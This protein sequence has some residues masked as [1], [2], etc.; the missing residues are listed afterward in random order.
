MSAT[1]QVAETFVSIQG[2]ST[3]AGLPCFFIRLSGCNLRCLYCDTRR[4]YD[5]GRETAV[6]QLVAAFPA[7]R[8]AIAEITGGEPLL[9]QGF[10][11]LALGL[12][13]QGGRP[14]LVETNGSC[15]LSVIPDGVIAIMDLKCPGS[16]EAGSMDF[17]N[18]A[19]LRPYDEVKFVVGDRRDFDWACGIVERS[20]LPDRCHAVLFSPVF[21]VLNAATLAEWVLE[22]RL[23]VRVQLPLHKTL[24]IR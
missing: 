9:Q 11:D 22:A 7:S 14:V 2:E 23:T 8:A 21:G 17:G 12:R 20:A 5:S 15:D 16:G 13:A 1:V 6:D 18:I 19:R 4:A 3:W 24:G 10:P